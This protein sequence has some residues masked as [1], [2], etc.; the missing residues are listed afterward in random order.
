MRAIFCER[1]KILCNICNSSGEKPTIDM[2]VQSRVEESLKK[3]RMCGTIFVFLGLMCF[4]TAGNNG[5]LDSNSGL[6][7]TE[8]TALSL[9][10]PL[11]VFVFIFSTLC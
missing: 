3:R 2:R 6:S 11:A 9:S 7:K 8:Q 10:L 5:Q 1:E 4:L